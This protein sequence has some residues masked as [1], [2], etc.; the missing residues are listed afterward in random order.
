MPSKNL[1][2]RPGEEISQDTRWMSLIFGPK[3]PIRKEL[4]EGQ[5]EKIDLFEAGL[6][7]EI[8]SS[9]TIDQAFTK[10]VRMALAAEF[11]PSFSKAKGT[12]IARH[13]RYIRHIPTANWN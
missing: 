10:V 2:P 6:A 12:A 5:E 3:A 8:N 1:A 7:K 4:E 11:G 13:I 9:D